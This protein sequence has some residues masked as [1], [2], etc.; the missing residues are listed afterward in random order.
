[1]GPFLGKDVDLPAFGAEPNSITISGISGGSF[2]ANFLHVIYSDTIHGAGLMI[3]GPYGD[4]S[5]W[6]NGYVVPNTNTAPSGIL[7]ANGYFQQNLI[8]DPVNLQNNP[9]YIFSGGIDDLALPIKQEAQRDFYNN[10]NSNVEFVQL[11]D[12]EHHVPSKFPNS[13]EDDDEPC[14]SS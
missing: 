14:V 12:I 13:Y 6:D 7:K 1:M 3:G 9:V 8:D 5:T 10:Y 11:S 4:D 2:A